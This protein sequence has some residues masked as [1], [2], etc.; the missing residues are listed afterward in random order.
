MLSELNKP[1]KVF[2][3]I[4]YVLA[5]LSLLISSFVIYNLL[6]TIKPETLGT[7]YAGTLSCTEEDINILEVKIHSNENKNGQA[8]YE[9]LWNGYVDYQGG[10]VKGFGMQS[11][12]KDGFSYPGDCTFKTINGE[13]VA[14]Y[15]APIKLYNT[16]DNGKSSY[17]VEDIPNELYIDIEGKFYKI[18]FKEFAYEVYQTKGW[19]WWNKLW[20]IKETKY[21]SY[22][23]Y[24]VFDYII[25]SACSDSAKYENGE[26]SIPLLD[27]S[28]YFEFWYQ[29]E[30]TQYKPLDEASTMYKFLKVH[31]TYSKDGLTDASQSLFK[32]V[33]GNSSWNYFNNTDAKEYW[34]AYSVIEL[35]ENHLNYVYDEVESAYYVTIDKQFANYLKGLSKAE[36]N[37]NLNLT[38]LDFETYAI[39]LENFDF[40][41]ESFEITTDREDFEIYSQQSCEIVPMIKVV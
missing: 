33:Y 15:M 23:F 5:G 10:A 32:Q 29:D 37:I 39:N 22:N 25:E 19:D 40:R 2:M 8:C 11:T 20:N 34:N 17:V 18:K 30:D 31:V 12:M 14:T 26:F 13:F 35:N 27:F 3:I 38:N 24:S 9:I 7:I 6:T 16:D 4:M 41:I 36:V 21:K 28:K 1:Q